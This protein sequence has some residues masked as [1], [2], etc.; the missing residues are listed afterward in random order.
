VKYSYFFVND[1][2]GLSL[3]R[4]AALGNLSISRIALPL[5]ISFITFS[6]TAYIVD[7]YR[8]RYP[9][10]TSLSVLLGYVLFFPHLV[11]GPILRPNGLMPQ[12]RQLR[13]ATGARFTLGFALFAIGLVKKLVFADTLASTVDGVFT[14]G[15]MPTSW[16]YLLAVYGFTMQIYCDFSGYTDMAIGLAYLLRIRLPTNFLRPYGSR[17]IVEFWR[18]WHVTLSFWLR[19]Y[20]YIALGGNRNGT[21]RQHCNLIVTMVLGGLWHGAAWTF[22]IW[23]FLHG[24]AISG[25]HLARQFL[26]RTVAAIP[27]WAGTLLTFHLV[28]LGWIYFRA[29]NVETA[30]RVLGGLWNFSRDGLGEFS[31]R[32]LFELLL[33]GIFA[34]SHR[35]DRHAAV[36]LAVRRWNRGIVWSI[37]GALFVIAI[38]VGQGSSG[39]FIYFDF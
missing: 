15:S 30:H 2:F 21:I 38:A 22:V 32:H 4:F 25:V 11:A 7:V 37:I 35:Y 13:A 9:A 12:L 6:V 19:D 17:S 10:E 18:R 26:P 31:R 24:L 16:E 36:R 39:K 1:V 23:G 14:V 8:G 27:D 28:T 5:G 20:L 33:L 29:P 3:A 34:V